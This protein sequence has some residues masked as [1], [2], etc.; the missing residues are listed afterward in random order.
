[1]RILFI[2]DVI[3]R[4]GRAI[5]QERLPGLIVNWKLD[6]VVVNGDASSKPE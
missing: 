6:F 4:S 3:G 2:G 1:M 5:V